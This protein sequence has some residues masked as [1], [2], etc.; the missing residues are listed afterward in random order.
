MANHNQQHIEK[1]IHHNQVG[2]IP[3]MQGWFTIHKSIKVIYH[4]DQ[5]KNEKLTDVEKF[6]IHS[7]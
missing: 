5:R 3:G 6:N 2:F 1:N 7:W 4:I